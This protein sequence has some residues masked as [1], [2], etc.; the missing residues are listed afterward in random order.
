NGK[1]VLASLDFLKFKYDL[2]SGKEIQGTLTV[3]YQFLI[4]RDKI[5]ASFAPIVGKPA[6][7]QIVWLTFTAWDIIDVTTMPADVEQRFE[8]LR[9]Y[10][11]VF[12]LAPNFEVLSAVGMPST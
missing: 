10:G 11:A 4:D 8:D 5:T 9:G 12:Q 2:L 6:D 7:F 3:T 1:I